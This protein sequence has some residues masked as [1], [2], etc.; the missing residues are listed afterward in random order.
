MDNYT[1]SSYYDQYLD[2]DLMKTTKG[3]VN[4]KTPPVYSNKHVRAYQDKMDSSKQIL[5]G[6]VDE[7]H[8]NSSKHTKQMKQMKQMKQ[9]KQTK[10]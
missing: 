10:S 9:T 5:K 6:S 1:G 3:K 8:V 7:S 4:K 2:E